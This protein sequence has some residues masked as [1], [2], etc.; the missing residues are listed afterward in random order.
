MVA[1]LGDLQHRIA[2]LLDDGPP[3]PDETLFCPAA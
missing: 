2:A 3:G 1:A